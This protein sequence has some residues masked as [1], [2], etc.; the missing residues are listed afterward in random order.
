MLKK[1]IKLLAGVAVAVFVV[2]Q[3]V[4]PRPTNPPSDPAAAFEAVARPSQE[5]ASTVRR[6]CRDCHTNETVWP[7]YGKV[8]PASW[9]VAKDVKEGRAK[10]NF[11]EWNRFSSEASN[12]KL[13]EVCDEV[14]K[15]E[16]PLWY[17]TPLHP[18]ANLTPGEVTALCAASVAKK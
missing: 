5:V 11:S 2:M 15:G 12:L 17:Y 16:M 18:E 14:K 8:W 4:Q 3:F 7:L 9:L 13:G 6:A 10:L 1:A